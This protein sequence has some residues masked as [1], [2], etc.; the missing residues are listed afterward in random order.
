[1][2]TPTH[3]RAVDED[4]EPATTSALPTFEGQIVESAR[5]KLTSVA[6]LE[7][8]GDD[9]FSRIDDIVR[10]FVE[11]RVVR[12]DH[13]VDELTGQLQRIQTVKVVDAIQLPWDFDAGQ[14]G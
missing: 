2:S 11:G 9:V 10:L 1:M 7:V 14:L 12:V 8:G 6:K 5:L 3:L 4:H 13:V